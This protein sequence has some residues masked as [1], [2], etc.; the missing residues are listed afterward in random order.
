MSEFFSSEKMQKEKW[1]FCYWD[2]PGDSQEYVDRQ[3]L[4]NKQIVEDD[5]ED[6]TDEE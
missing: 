1:V 4:S 5:Y 3:K 6:Q 2:D